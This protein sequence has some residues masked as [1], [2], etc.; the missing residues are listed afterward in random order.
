MAWGSGLGGSFPHLLTRSEKPGQVAQERDALGPPH[1]RLGTQGTTTWG[2]SAVQEAKGMALAWERANVQVKLP[3]EGRQLPCAHRED[4][5]W[6]HSKQGPLNSTGTSVKGRSQPVV[7]LGTS[8]VAGSALPR[9]SGDT[10]H[11]C[12]HLH[13][14]TASQSSAFPSALSGCSGGALG[15]ADFPLRRRGTQ[16]PWLCRTLPLTSSGGAA[17]SPRA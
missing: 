4:G 16:A 6:C 14:L 15:A 1:T 5:E 3:A 9:G 11:R 7:V 12:Q 2:P 17:L 13:N 10:A 8:P